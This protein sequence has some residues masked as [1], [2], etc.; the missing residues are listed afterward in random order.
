[1]IYFI[2]GNPDKIFKKANSIVDSLLKKNSG[3]NLLKIDSDNFDNFN[4]DEMIGGQSLFTIKQI[5]YLKRLFEK[6]DVSESL[7]KRI[8]ELGQSNNIFII[9]EEK[10]DK[11][12]FTAIEKQSEK[13]Q[14]FD[15]K[16]ENQQKEN[17]FDLTEALGRRDPKK[18][19]LL[20]QEKIR[21]N[22]PEEIHGI[23]W[24]QI[25]TMLMVRNSKNIEE[26]GLKPFVFKKAES[27]NQ[28]YSNAEINDISDRLINILHNSRRNGLELELALEKFVLSI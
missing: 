14:S 10:L 7:L 12:T 13:I 11:K 25:K 1:M 22:R 24:W 27:F 2:Y 19:W 16:K 18:L 6:K 3:S 20:Y 15:V 28:N 26:T 4:I 23:L 5:I 8:K 21:K 17:I 9:V